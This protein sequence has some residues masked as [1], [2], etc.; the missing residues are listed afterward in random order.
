MLN[1]CDF[2]RVFVITT[3]HHLKF[4]KIMFVV[5]LD[6]VLFAVVVFLFYV[7]SKH[8]RSCRGGQLT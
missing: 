6:K 3:N 8:L 4:Y 1:S 7:H 5:H 2:I